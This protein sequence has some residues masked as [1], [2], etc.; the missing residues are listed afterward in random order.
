MPKLLLATNNKGKVKEYKKL[1]GGLALTL[2]SPTELGINAE[3]VE[4]G[5]TFADNATLKA[6][7]MS[8]R[9][10]LAALADDSGLEVTALDGQPGVRSARYAGE[11]KSDAERV[12]FLLEKLKDV[13]P[14]KRSA[15]FICVIAITIPQGEVILCRGECQG[16]IATEPKGDKGFGYDPV[17]FIPELGKTIAELSPQQKNEVSHRGKAARKAAAVLKELKL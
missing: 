1:L 16:I 17:F 13:P 11:N 9:S 10:G 14:H 8:R 3:V 12:A 15:R 5:S 7:E 2:L 4:T 6:T